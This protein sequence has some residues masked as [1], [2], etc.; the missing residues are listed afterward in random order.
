MSLRKKILLRLG[1]SIFSLLLIVGIFTA[2]E[3]RGYGIKSAEKEA[4][5]IA[6]LVKSGLTAHM[7]TGTMNMRDYF[8]KQIED[9]KEIENLRI[10]RGDKVNKQFG[11]GRFIEE[12]QDEIDIKTLETG[13]TQKVVKEFGDKVLFRITIPYIATTKGNPNCLTCHTNAKEG[14]VLGAITIETDISDTKQAAIFTLKEIGIVSFLL[15]IAVGAYMS[16]FLGKYISLFEKLKE[17]M[18]KALKGDFSAQIDTKLNDEAGDTAKEF[19]AFLRE[20]KENFNEIKKVMDALGSGNLS[21]RI[22]KKMEGEFEKLK[23]SINTSIS[24]LDHLFLKM[25]KDFNMV[26]QDIE[27]I[28]KEL[29]NIVNNIKEQN[30]SIHQINGSL[31][32]LADRI[33]SL[34]QNVNKAQYIGIEV[35]ENIDEEWKQMNLI[36][37][38]INTLKEASQ[39]IEYM[40]SQIISISDQTN[41]L[42]LNASIEAAKAGEHGTGFTVVAEEIRKLAENTA[43][44]AKNIQGMVKEIMKIISNTEKTT[45]KAHKG[46]EKVSNLYSELKTFLDTIVKDLNEQT[47]SLKQITKN[48]E[49]I[50]EISQNNTQKNKE[51]VNKALKIA[52]L[53][54]DVQEKV[55]MFKT[56]SD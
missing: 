45:D 35:K 12:P 39:K 40:V 14:D 22:E 44:F 31:E 38:S 52:K 56:N 55:N 36:K 9:I 16:V 25:K 24:S 46:Y 13:K 23:E 10:V 11:K 29:E 27:E 34:N 19:N 54:Q 53:T 28:S 8:L 3:F 43:E 21:K 1:I 41:L 48:M 20:L 4:K 7:I 2:L 15:F 26:S 5:V 17:S 18:N 33:S 42:A 49:K 50:A 30:T 32:S 6:E 51:I 37:E 47:K